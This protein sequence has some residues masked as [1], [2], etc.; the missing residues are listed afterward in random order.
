MLRV[1]KGII[2]A[3]F[4]ILIGHL[5]FTTAA[6]HPKA[7]KVIVSVFL[8]MLIIT[9]LVGVVFVVKD[10]Y[11]S[12]SSRLKK[13]EGESLGHYHHRQQLK[14]EGY[15]PEQ[16]N[17]AEQRD[18]DYYNRIKEDATGQNSND[19]DSQPSDF[20][21]LCFSFPIAFIIIYFIKK[22]RKKRQLILNQETA[23]STGV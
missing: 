9:F 7:I 23:A 20:I 14:D 1:I 17:Y 5:I 21:V 18:E 8:R 11:D 15:T 2:N 13:W 22:N 3:I 19:S 12:D 10:S 4:I 16:Y 6:E